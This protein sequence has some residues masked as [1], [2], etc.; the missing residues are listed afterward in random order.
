M[1]TDAVVAA[2]DVLAALMELRR[3]GHRRAL[4]ELESLEPELMEFALEEVTAI[5]HALMATRVRPRELR[6]LTR[7]VQAMAIVL[8]TSLRTAR[9]R[10]WRDAG[11]QSSP[12]LPSPPAEPGPDVGGGPSHPEMPTEGPHDG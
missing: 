9:L 2:R 11:P 1:A 8:V 10:L 5:H 4:S 7:R 12:P 6:R 3:T